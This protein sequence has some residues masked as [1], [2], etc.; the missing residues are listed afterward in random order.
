[1]HSRRRFGWEGTPTLVMGTLSYLS[2]G[3]EYP[4]SPHEAPRQMVCFLDV[5]TNTA[6]GVFWENS[7]SCGAK[8]L[9]IMICQRWSDHV[10]E[11]MASRL[12]GGWIFWWTKVTGKTDSDQTQDRCELT[13]RRWDTRCKH[14]CCVVLLTDVRSALAFYVSFES[15]HVIVHSTHKMITQANLLRLETGSITALYYDTPLDRVTRVQ[16]HASGTMLVIVASLVKLYVLDLLPRLCAVIST[17]LRSVVTYRNWKSPFVKQSRIMWFPNLWCLYR[18][19]V[20]RFGSINIDSRLPMYT[21]M[22]LSA[23]TN[24]LRN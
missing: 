1:M 3:G 20:T 13:W 8:R 21:L 6:P 14:S 11:K 12:Q 15:W 16:I 24:S 18:L 23:H 5:D 7:G 4:W 2:L 9:S 10:I 17:I 19:L 22:G